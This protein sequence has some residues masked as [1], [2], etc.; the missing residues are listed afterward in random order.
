[1]RNKTFLILTLA[2]VLSALI[3]AGSVLAA[4]PVQAD[5]SELVPLL[6]QLLVPSVLGVVV[7]IVLSYVV[8]VWPAY[9]KL[10]PKWK[11]LAFFGLAT[12]VGVAAGVGVAYFGK[13]PFVWDAIIANAV[14]TAL[15]AMSGGTLAH[16]GRLPAA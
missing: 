9:E 7:G 1:M 6:Q 14:V 2:L 15:A 11:R 13:Q 4:Y 16:T 3:G 5:E 8:E 10:N 12:V